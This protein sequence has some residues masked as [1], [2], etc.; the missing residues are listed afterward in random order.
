MKRRIAAILAGVT[1]TAAG[2]Y[3]FAQ[4]WFSSGDIHYVSLLML[5]SGAALAIVEARRSY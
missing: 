2:L 1:L 3:L 4:S 5:V